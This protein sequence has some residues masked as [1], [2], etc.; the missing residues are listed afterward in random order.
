M[1]AEKLD[2]LAVM[3]KDLR[4]LIQIKP[5]NAHA[6]NALGYT[7]AERGIRLDE[8]RQLTEKA[9]S[10]APDDPLIMDSLGW[11]YFRLGQT[12]KAVELL[13]KALALRQDPEIAAHL[14][15]ALWV[16]GQR[17]EARKIWQTSLKQAPDNEVLLNVMQKYK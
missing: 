10:L 13:R 11:T 16:K 12:D 1:A 9:L 4:Q 8:A 14:G 6:Y 5:D 17:D 7:F 15:E 3:E 2:Q